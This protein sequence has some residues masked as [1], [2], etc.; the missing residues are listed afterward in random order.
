MG[1]YRGARPLQEVRLRNWRGGRVA[2]MKLMISRLEDALNDTL[3]AQVEQD[4]TR[5]TS[6]QVPF[7]INFDVEG[8]YRLFK[9]NFPTPPGLTNLLFYEIQHDDN[10]AFSSPVTLRT[11]MNN[12]LISGV[13]LGE[14]R[15]FRARVV[16]TSFEASFWTDTIGV[17]AA[18]G[19]IDI[20]DASGISN[21]I[22]QLKSDT[23]VFTDIFEFDYTPTGGAIT[24]MSHIGLACVVGA[25]GLSGTGK[26]L[27]EDDGHGNWYKQ[28]GPSHA[29]F[30]WLMNGKPVR[31]PRALL[32]QRPF[33]GPDPGFGFVQKSPWSMIDQGTL[34]TP[35]FR[36][37]E[38]SINIKLQA[39]LNLGSEWRGGLT[40]ISPPTSARAE[41]PFKIE[42]LVLARN[43][44]II[45]VQEEF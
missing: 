8:G 2:A 21:I 22:V 45:E 32:S 37:E 25:K 7:I 17:T 12:I 41:G 40:S 11:P 26:E 27:R 34:I 14:T 1:R 16:N 24:I 28:F 18:R 36:T 30:R 4:L 38:T 23:P 33:N 9:V 35:F 3:G 20:V 43:V 39:A 10:S 44:K 6:D 5:L 15:Y 31:W 19:K 13:G 42:P 29:Q